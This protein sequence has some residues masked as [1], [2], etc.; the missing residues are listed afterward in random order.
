MA[1]VSKLAD[2]MALSAEQKLPLGQ[3]DQ[4]GRAAA[5]ALVGCRLVVLNKETLGLEEGIRASDLKLFSKLVEVFCPTLKFIP[6]RECPAH[7]CTGMVE[8]SSAGDAGRRQVLVAGGQG[9]SPGKAALSCLGELSER[10]SLFS[11]G[12][13]DPRVASCSD[14]AKD[15]DL[16]PFL[17]FSVEQERYLR[18]QNPKL[19]SGHGGNRVPWNSLSERRV[20]V[21]CLRSGASANLPAYGVLFG[22]RTHADL[23]IPGFLTSSGTAVWSDLVTATQKAVFELAERDAFA[24]AW[25]NRLGITRV[26]EHRWD[27]FFSEKLSQF[28]N[29]RLRTTGLYRVQ[30]DLGTHVL[31]AISHDKNG[32]AACLGVAAS[33]VAREAACSAV[34]EM[35]QGELALELAALSYRAD[36]A[37][38]NASMPGALRTAAKLRIT[39]D[40]GLADLPVADMGALSEDFEP[41]ALEASCRERGIDLWRFDATRPDID[42]PCARVF[43]PQLCSWQPRFGNKRL[44][45]GVIDRGLAVHPREEAE[46]ASRPF[47]F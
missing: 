41:G 10:V 14:L 46:F 21:T 45:G 13:V 40:L 9:D 4:A 38:G 2:L 24:Q 27:D 17:G 31:A 19:N 28:L 18:D 39:S 44:Y 8:L 43:S 11:M 30:T 16:A 5:Q 25:Y 20:S 26:P 34:L 37:K 12:R 36:L 33:A 42:V 3:L 23:S 1:A 47:P 32:Q 15:L 29:E 22:E 6:L 35:L 7:F